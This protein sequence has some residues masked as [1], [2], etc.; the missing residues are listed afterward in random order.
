ML[1]HSVV[2]PGDVARERAVIGE[3]LRMIADDPQDWSH[4]LAEEMLWPG[5]PLGREIAGS[6]ETV[7]RLR[8]RDVTAHVRHWYGANNAVICVAGGL[9]PSAV[10][11]LVCEAFASWDEVEVSTPPA[12][13]GGSTAAGWR[14]E[15]KPFEQ[16][17]ACVAYPGVPREHPDRAP[18]E[19]LT[20]ILGGGASARLFEELRERRGLVYDI[21]AAAGHYRDTGSVVVSFGTDPPKAGVALQAV[22]GEI[23]RLQRRRVLDVEM[24]KARQFFRGRL[25]LALEDTNAVAGWFGSQEILQDRV[26]SPEEAI[27]A[28]DAVTRDDVRRVAREYLRADRAHVVGVGPTAA[29]L[30]RELEKGA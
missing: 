12:P 29:L 10:E 6:H 2:R 16:L 4:V 3:E 7:E 15:N 28:I 17:N 24:D 25:W 19:V 22:L 26:I 21:G 5:H 1:Q 14:L 13:A 8:R 9:E 20:I 27:A 30:A 11:R 23:E 18:L